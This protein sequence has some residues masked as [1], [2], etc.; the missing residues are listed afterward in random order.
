MIDKTKKYLEFASSLSFFEFS[1]EE[2][3]HPNFKI[4]NYKEEIEL[5]SGLK[6]ISNKELNNLIKKHPKI[7]D[8]LEQ[9]FQLYRFTNTQMI[10]FLFD[11]EILNS[12][13]EKKV[14]DY[15]KNNLDLD[16]NFKYIFD[17][18]LGKNDIDVNIQKKVFENDPA[19]I[20]KLFKESI[21][22][23]IETSSKK[24]EL[25]YFRLTNYDNSRNRLS[26]YLINNL[27]LNEMLES[28]NLEA[29]LKNKRIPK[30]TK[31]IHGKF[32]NIKINK[33]LSGN[34]FIKA[35]EIFKE[36]GIKELEVDLKKFDLDEF[37]GKSIF[38]TEKYIKDIIKQKQKK[39]KKFDFI[40]IKDLK[41]ISAI[42]TNFYSTSGT[43]IGI[44]EEE[45]IDLNEEIKEKIPGVDFIWITDGNYW[46]TSDG[47]S[48]FKGDL[49][50][51][52]ENIL[53]YNLFKQRLLK[54]KDG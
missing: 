15:L 22:S 19:L 30:D 40:I 33:I 21:I 17:K 13:D 5:L 43:K 27:K 25:I 3:Y 20:I 47:E 4:S 52:K 14:I 23:Y 50:Y 37:K 34:G 10:N 38:V 7:F 35:D 6:S 8:L 16:K 1:Q 32:G 46:L 54:F 53:T 24:R 41:I 36:K 29:Y 26:N 42:E 28:V 18:Y 44:N 39:K 51:F 49:D 45:Y 31:S 11:I 9:I 48:R 12:D 2:F